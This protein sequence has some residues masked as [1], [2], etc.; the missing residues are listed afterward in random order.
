M[1]V[2]SFNVEMTSTNIFA[3]LGDT[4]SSISWYFSCCVLLPI[5]KLFLHLCT[6][7]QYSVLLYVAIAIIPGSERNLDRVL[8]DD[9][10]QEVYEAVYDA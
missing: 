7:E 9:D 1:I 5:K 4:P 3:L 6:I 8:T 10:L 2:L